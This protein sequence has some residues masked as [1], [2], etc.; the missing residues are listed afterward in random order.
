MGRPT[1]IERFW[2]K[3]NRNGPVPKVDPSLGPCWLWTKAIQNGY[4]IFTITPEPYKHMTVKAHRWI[5]QQEIGP[6]T[7]TLDHLC[8]VR[9]CI[10]PSH[11]EDVTMGENNT[12]ST[13]HRLT[14]DACP[15]GHPF[16]EFGRMQGGY[17]VCRLCDNERHRERR[18]RLRREEKE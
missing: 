7:H 17:P 12:R 15:K 10:R 16:D 13:G 5:Y 4:G 9:H 2:V 18:A 1:D 8:R 3:V 11:L 14:R 6:I